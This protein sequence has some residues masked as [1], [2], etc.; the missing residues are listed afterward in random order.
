MKKLKIY[1]EFPSFRDDTCGKD[2][3]GMQLISI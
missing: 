2:L 3:A 1:K